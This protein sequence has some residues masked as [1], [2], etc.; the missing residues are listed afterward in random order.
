MPIAEHS[1][2]ASGNRHEVR[3]DVG[4]YVLDL[5]DPDAGLAEVEGER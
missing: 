2:D 3:A 1:R 4:V 5:V